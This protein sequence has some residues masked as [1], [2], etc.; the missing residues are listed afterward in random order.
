MPELKTLTLH[1][2]TPVVPHGAS[3]P[4]DVKRTVTLP[5]LIHLDI[6]A[7]ARDCGFALAHL[8]LLALTWLCLMARSCRWDGSDVREILLYVSR[9]AHGPKD[10]QSLQS[11]FVSSER[12]HT[13]ILAWTK[14][15]LD[16]E[17]HLPTALFVAT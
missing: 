8:V 5:S 14:P 2:A 15:D 7:P 1:L 3:L 9:H 10:A 4:S 12:M 16:V 17:L 13:H 6:S 11:V